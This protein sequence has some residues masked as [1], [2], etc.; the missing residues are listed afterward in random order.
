LHPKLLQMFK[1]A[2]TGKSRDPLLFGDVIS[3]L[4]RTAKTDNINFDVQMNLKKLHTIFLDVE[5][6]TQDLKVTE[7]QKAKLEVH[8]D[9]LSNGQET[10]WSPSRLILVLTFT[11]GLAYSSLR[12]VFSSSKVLIPVVPT[13]GACMYYLLH[14]LSYTYTPRSN[15]QLVW[16]EIRR[17]G[18]GLSSSFKAFNPKLIIFKSFSILPPLLIPRKLSW[19]RAPI[20]PIFNKET[21]IYPLG[22]ISTKYPVQ[23]DDRDSNAIEFS[24]I[25]R[26]LNQPVK[27]DLKALAEFI[28]KAKSVIKNILLKHDNGALIGEFKIYTFLEW[29]EHLESTKKQRYLTDKREFDE[30][31]FESFI[32]LEFNIRS[33]TDFFK[34]KPPR[35]ISQPPVCFVKVVAPWIYSAGQILKKVFNKESLFYYT[36][37]GTHLDLGHFDKYVIEL[38]GDCFT[39]INDFSTFDTTVLAEFFDLEYFTYEAM[40][41]PESVLDYINSCK[42]VHGR[43][44]DGSKYYVHGTRTS[45]SPNTSCGN[46]LINVLL[47]SYAL[48]KVCNLKLLKDYAIKAIGDDSDELIPMKH[49]TLVRNKLPEINSVFTSLGMVAKLSIVIDRPNSEYVSAIPWQI[50]SKTICYSPKIGRLIVKLGYTLKEPKNFEQTL[51]DLYYPFTLYTFLPL[52][53]ELSTHVCTT[54]N[55]TRYN[56]DDQKDYLLK[57]S[58]KEFEPKLIREQFYIRYNMDL[59]PILLHWKAFISKIHSFPCNVIWPVYVDRIIEIDCG[60]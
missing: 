58:V 41:A 19:Y 46:T 52:I 12:R 14:K 35:N 9:I 43:A 51:Y 50:T 28:I 17:Y 31:E 5:N 38:L 25:N 48:F 45:G 27:P 13:I 3:R 59:E 1:N 15:L 30:L 2:I 37:G 40:R 26:V 54:L 21:I 56:V 57:E 18:Y 7:L 23:V 47:I 42:E 16:E 36:S 4:I 49:L 34:E 22:V 60:I 39:L 55:C 32:K 24:I 33:T 53:Y 10:K 44:S 11:M 20:E 6:E 29:I 8:E